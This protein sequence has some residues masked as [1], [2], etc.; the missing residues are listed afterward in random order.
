MRW[1]VIFKKK[2]N[3]NNIPIVDKP[4][5][6]LMFNLGQIYSK[7]SAT[8]IKPNQ[9]VQPSPTKFNIITNPSAN[10]ST[11]NYIIHSIIYQDKAHNSNAMKKL[12]RLTKLIFY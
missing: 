10:R 1:K 2:Q 6:S 5:F 12:V 3:V 11:V 8:N 9:A 4:R 7:I